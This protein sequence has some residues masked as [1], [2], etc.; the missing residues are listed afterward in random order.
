MKNIFLAGLSFLILF[1]CQ[2]TTDSSQ[3]SQTV[4]PKMQK[5]FPTPP[6]IAKKPKEFTEHGVKRTDNYYW[7][8]EKENPEVIAYLKA[9]NTYFDTVMHHTAALQDKLYQEMRGRIKEEDQGVPTA[10]NGYLYYNRTEKD[11]QYRLYARKK[12]SAEAAEELL[13]DGN[14]MAEGKSYSGWAV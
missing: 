10:D 12:G 7:L 5:D 8:R 6:T 13:I 14:K 3:T 11:K 9:E 4:I 2:K 1:S